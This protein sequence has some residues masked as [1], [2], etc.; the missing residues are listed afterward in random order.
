M[1]V[2]SADANTDIAM[3]TADPTA[4]AEAGAAVEGV[5]TAAAEAAAEM[6]VEAAAEII[7]AAAAVPDNAAV[8][9]TKAVRHVGDTARE[10]VTVARENMAG[11]RPVVE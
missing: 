2:E 8:E 11:S 4:V 6:V 7:V 3:A 5:E 9:T 10:R 1:E